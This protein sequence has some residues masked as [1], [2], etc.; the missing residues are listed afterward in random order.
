MLW[1]RLDIYRRGEERGEDAAYCLYHRYHKIKRERETERDWKSE[2]VQ[3]EFK[4]IDKY[5]KLM[6]IYVQT[7]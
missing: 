2:K 6:H 4:I 3:N 7:F 1:L 5:F